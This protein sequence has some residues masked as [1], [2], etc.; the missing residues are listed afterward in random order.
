MTNKEY[1]DRNIGLTFD[2]L[3]E[4]LKSPAILEKIPDNATLEFVEKDFTKTEHPNAIKPD[5]YIKVRSQFEM[6]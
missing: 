2:F 6:I 4:I 3:R 1:I 5:A